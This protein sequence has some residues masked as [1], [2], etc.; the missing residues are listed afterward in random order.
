MLASLVSFL[1]VICQSD[2]DTEHAIFLITTMSSGKY[3]YMDSSNLDPSS[4]SK[5]LRISSSHIATFGVV[6]ALW[7]GGIYVVLLQTG[8]VDML[9]HFDN[10]F[11]YQRGITPLTSSLTVAMIISG[12]AFDRIIT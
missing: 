7:L 3:T 4:Q 10:S 1:R 5:A 12:Y 11:R 6:G 2:R 8:V 9:S